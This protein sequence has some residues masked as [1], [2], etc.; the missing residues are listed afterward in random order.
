MTSYEVA[1]LVLSVL[2]CYVLALLCRVGASGVESTALRRIGGR[3]NISVKN[4]TVHL[5][6]GIGVGYR[7]EQSLS[8]WGEEDS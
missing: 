5:H 3:R 8:V 6:V 2:R 1:G 4:D 7:R